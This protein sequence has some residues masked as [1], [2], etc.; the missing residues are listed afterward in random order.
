MLISFLQ[1]KMKIKIKTTNPKNVFEASLGKTF[2]ITFY[3]YHLHKMS[4][5]Y[6]LAN[7]KKKY[8]NPITIKNFHSLKNKNKEIVIQI[9]Q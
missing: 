5:E 3:S 4:N 2:Q 8:S 9:T 1:R 7:L 6:L